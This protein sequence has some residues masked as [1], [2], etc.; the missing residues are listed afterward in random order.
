MPDYPEEVYS[1]DGDIID[2]VSTPDTLGGAPRL[3]GHRIAVYHILSFY[4]NSYSIEDIAGDEIYPHL[5]ESQ[6]RAALHYA[7]DYSEAVERSS[8][9]RDTPLI[10]DVSFNTKR[11]GPTLSIFAR[12]SNEPGAIAEVTLSI[13]DLPEGYDEQDLHA[14]WAWMHEQGDRPAQFDTPDNLEEAKQRL[15][16]LLDPYRDRSDLSPE[17]EAKVQGYSNALAVLSGEELDECPGR[18]DGFETPEMAEFIDGNQ[19]AD[20]L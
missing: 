6:V 1:F 2:I 16:R 19:E 7:V 15:R 3:D 9:P 11:G 10:M 12:D 8:K 20:D 14:A 13:E 18:D 17:M 4:R 5:S